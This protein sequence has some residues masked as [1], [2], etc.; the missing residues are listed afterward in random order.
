MAYWLFK[1]EPST[2]AID[3]LARAKTDWWDGV[4]NYQA[5]NFM[6][7]DMRIGDGVLFYHSSCPVPGIAGEAKISRTARPD[8]TQFS[9]DSLY[10]DATATPD[11]PR[12]WYV[13]VMFVKKFSR[14]IPLAELKANPKLA[15][16]R[17]LQRGNRLSITP[18]TS[19]EWQTIQSLIK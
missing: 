10:Y 7:D 6:R 19:A 13:Q 3:D 11:K 5:C 17:I 1:S 9:P 15:T 18:I 12:W 8:E 2:Y 14:F 4:R 16:M